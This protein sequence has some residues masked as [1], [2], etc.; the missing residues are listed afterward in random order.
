MTTI[1]TGVAPRAAILSGAGFSRLVARIASA[2]TARAERRRTYRL[3][4]ALSAHE[5][6][7]IGLTRAEVEA[8]R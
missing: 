3:L 2:W 6:D 8:M 1:D 5:L 4:S 7:D